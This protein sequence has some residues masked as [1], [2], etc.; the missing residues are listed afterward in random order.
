MAL[1]DSGTPLANVALSDTFN[2]WRVRTNQIN[3]QAAGLASN[4]TFTGTNNIFNGTLQATTAN[5]TT[6]QAD[7]IDFDGDLTVDN[8]TANTAAFNGAVTAPIVTANTVNATAA[9]FTTLQ[10][11]AIDFD[12][13]LTVD[14][15]TANTLAGT[16]STAS[17]TNITALGTLTDLTVTNPI[18]GSVTGT[19]A[20][21]TTAGTVTTA[22]QPNITSLG[23][24]TGLT[25]AG[26]FDLKEL[27]ETLVALGST[28]TG[29]NIDLTQGTVFS[30]T[31]TQNCTFTVQNPNAVSSFIL[32]LTNDGSSGRSVAWSGGTFRYPGGSVTRSTGANDVDIWFVTTIDSGS[33]YYVS[34]PMLDLS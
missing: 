16:I 13:D 26:Q 32:V 27:G 30:A 17:Q 3:T 21:A 7:A 10:A 33:T 11:D 15:V 4:N 34:I 25:V 6:L 31:L 9:N 22:A 12:G 20:S 14:N 1:F 24:L 18:A 28:G 8:V 5:F 2:T 29:Q 19:A 23:S